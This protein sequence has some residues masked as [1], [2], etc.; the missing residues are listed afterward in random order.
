MQCADSLSVYT[1]Y[2]TDTEKIKSWPEKT[3]VTPDFSSSI[4]GTG[5]EALS[6]MIASDDLPDILI[7]DLSTQPGGVQNYAD[8]WVIIDRTDSIKEYARCG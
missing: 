1:A 7:T 8:D 4:S 5:R 3:G 6:L 2:D